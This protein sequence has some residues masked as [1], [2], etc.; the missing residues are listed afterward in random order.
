MSRFLSGLANCHLP[1]LYSLVLSE[2]QNS[3]IGM[4]RVFY[5]GKDCKM[6]LWEG[7][8]F[9]LK[10]HNHRQSIR[11]KL[12]RGDAQNISINVGFG[13]LRLWCYRF[14]SALL[15]GSFTLERMFY[16]NA[17]TVARRIPEDGLYLHWNE[18]HT[19]TAEP[20]AAWLVE[21]LE[22]APPDTARCWS[23]SD[24]LQLSNDGLYRPMIAEEI[25][26][27]EELIYGK[28]GAA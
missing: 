2:R 9:R 6:D 8:D 15:D 24:H 22:L 12:L 10:P 21:E 25:A 4:R 18:V 13:T 17:H 5:V 1:G 14:G 7:A 23:V 27:I 28:A 3:N 19:V 20:G 11:L 16:E 26:E